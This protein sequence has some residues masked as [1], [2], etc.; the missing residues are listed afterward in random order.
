MPKRLNV[1]L[2]EHARCSP[3][4]AFLVRITEIFLCSVDIFSSQRMPPL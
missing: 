1:V 4:P 2:V 3:R